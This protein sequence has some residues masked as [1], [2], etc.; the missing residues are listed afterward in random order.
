MKKSLLYLFALICSV[1]LF[2]ACSDDDDEVK[3][4]VDNELAGVYKGTMDVYYVNVPEPIASDLI[5]KVYISKASDTS[6]KLELRDFSINVAGNPLTIGTI[7]VDACAL[8]PNGDI[9]QFSGN[10]T[11]KLKVGTCNISVSGEI[12]KNAVDMVINVDVDGG[13]MKVKVEYEGTKLSGNESSE[14]KITSFTFDPKKYDF[15][16]EQPIINEE[17]GTIVF[18][19][20][21]GTS[22]E[23]LQNMLPTIAISEKATISPDPSVKQD[24]SNG[25]TVVYTVTAE[26]G[27]VKRYAISTPF[28]QLVNDFETWMR[29]VPA[30]E[31]AFYEVVGWTSSNV[32][33]YMLMNM[34]GFA[35]SY[36]VTKTTDAHSGNAAA[37]IESIDTKGG[38]MIL[39]K[40]PKVTTGS[41][42]LG[43]FSIE[44]SS[45]LNSTKFGIPFN[46][47]PVSLKG[48]YKYTPGP[49]F[50]T[51]ESPATC[52]VAK[53][54][55]DKVDEFAIKAVLYETEEY[56]EDLSD[57]LTG[58]AGEN[59]IYTSNR[60]VAMASLE[61]GEQT[62]WK[63]FNL[64][65]EYK[66]NYDPNKKYRFTIVCSASKEGDKFWGAPGSVLTVDDF[67]LTVE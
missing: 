52:D 28:F 13:L 23:K 51:C 62:T 40:V 50:Y 1:S 48:Y 11:L 44:I 57:C 39:A 15:V 42:F 27:T 4:P 47:K 9:Y 43:E 36:V 8:K 12:G 25:K 3:Y 45:T 33:A 20:T 60:I 21:D 35:D 5:Q 31:N 29:G 22:A 37:R 19:V 54:D 63:S 61:G 46:K 67:E 7:T 6:I 14:A 56:K 58:V 10:Q 17:A 18:R 2:T 65:F 26:D 24:F 66:K 41:L 16:S 34:G 49:V 55:P 59:N 64:E 53:V 30:A 38:D 32:G